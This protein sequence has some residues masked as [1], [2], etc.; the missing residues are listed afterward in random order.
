[1]ASTLYSLTVIPLR[2]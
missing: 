1:M 2:P